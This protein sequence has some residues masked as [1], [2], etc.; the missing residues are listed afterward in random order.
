MNI[1]SFGE[2]KCENPQKEKEESPQRDG[3]KKNM[4]E[5]TWINQM[6]MRN[7]WIIMNQSVPKQSNLEPVTLNI[8]Q[9]THSTNRI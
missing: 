3:T 8:K 7:E 6:M 1:H 4:S 2:K 5:K 9:A